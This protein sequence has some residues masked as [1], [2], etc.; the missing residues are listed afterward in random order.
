VKIGN[1]I[2]IFSAELSTA[3]EEYNIDATAALKDMLRVNGTVQFKQESVLEVHNDG[4]SD[5]IF[6]NQ[7]GDKPLRL[8][9]FQEIDKAKTKTLDAYTYGPQTGRYFAALE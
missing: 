9:K 7:Y 6:T 4:I 8:G 3:P 1:H 5:L 2:L